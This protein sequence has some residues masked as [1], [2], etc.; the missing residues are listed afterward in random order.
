MGQFMGPRK[1]HGIC[2]GIFFASALTRAAR[3]IYLRILLPRTSFDRRVT[4]VIA[5]YA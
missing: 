2:H 1:C 3:A 4:R 5:A